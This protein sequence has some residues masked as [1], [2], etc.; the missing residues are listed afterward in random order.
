MKGE[1]GLAPGLAMRRGSLMERSS[2]SVMQMIEEATE[3]HKKE[4]EREK[5]ERSKS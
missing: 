1:T 5:G 3:K 2:F 4:L